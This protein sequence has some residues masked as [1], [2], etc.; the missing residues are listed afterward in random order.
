MQIKTTK[1]VLANAIIEALEDRR[2]LSTYTVTSTAD[3]GA[4]SLRQAIL[5]ANAH[6]GADTIAFAIGSGARTI[7]PTKALPGLGDGTTLDATTQPGYA[8]KPLITLSGVAAGAVDGLKITGGGVTVRGLNIQRFSGCGIM[9][10]GT[11]SNQIAGCFIGTDAGGTLA[12]GNGSHGILVQ[13]PN[14][15]IGG[16]S[17]ADRNVISGNTAAGI[18][19]Y[20]NVAHHNA[21]QGNYIGTDVSGTKSIANKNGV[22]VNNG[23]SNAIG[24]LTPGARNVLSS[25]IHD[26]VL[27]YGSGAKENVVQGN[28][29]GTD[30][31]GTQ[32]LGNGWYGV[33]ISQSNNVVGG[34][35]AA[36]RNI[37]SAN[38]HGG[39]VMY[40]ITA[41]GNRVQGNYVGTDVTGT[42]D[43]GNTGRGIEFTDG[44]SNN[45]VGGTKASERNVISGND[46]GGVGFY[47]G[48]HTNLLQGNYIGTTAA[49]NAAL[50]NT[51]A[52]VMVTFNA[53]S[54][55]IGGRNTG[56]IISGNSKEGIFLGAGTGASIVWGNKIGTDAAGRK[57]LGNALDGILVA[58]SRNQIGGKRKGCGNLISGNMQEGV[59]F[60][61]SSG[62][63]VR[64]NVIGADISGTRSLGNGKNGVIGMDLKTTAIGGNLVAFNGNHGVQI[65]TGTG[66]TI[67]SNSIHDNEGVG[68]NLGWDGAGA[69]AAGA[70]AGQKFPVVTTAKTVG[71]FT[72]IAGNVTA[73]A[74]QTIYLELFS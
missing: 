49:G 67:V 13:S 15:T 2:L 73:G 36:A 27:I 24:G 63:L 16:T 61:S 19:F 50:G 45:R 26:G 32:R 8:G 28:F 41:T 43:L 42:K 44:A 14:N 17:A 62:N 9:V 68:I 29:I 58:S 52:G 71:D 55:Y 66:N 12:A 33:E 10:L 30:V 40:L 74:N 6:S 46:L 35:N 54:N 34:A 18:F 60:N 64:R 7:T 56:N 38:G 1:A 20:L 70:N 11:G 25:N 72:S 5:D 37:V 3:A 59:K 47:S 31:T 22:H 4:G 53:G 57:K 69:N 51:G 39:I 48:A 65:A 23:H 21:V